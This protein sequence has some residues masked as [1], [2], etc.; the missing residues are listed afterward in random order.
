MKKVI[1]IL[2]AVFLL[3]SI[4]FAQSTSALKKVLTL[5]ITTEGGANGAGVVWHP[6]HKKYYA[7]MAGNENFQMG[8]FDAKGKLVSSDTLTTMVDLRGLWYNPK[9]N[10]IQSNAYA[11][12]GWNE[13][14]L[15]KNGIPVGI[16]NLFE[17]MYQPNENGVG[18]YNPT[19]NQVYFLND[20]DNLLI[21]IYNMKD[22]TAIE[23]KLKLHLQNVTLN[24]DKDELYLD[25]E[26][27]STTALYT[28]IIKKEILLLNIDQN[29]IEFYNLKNGFMTS[30]KKFPEDT[31]LESMFNFAYANGIFWLFNKADR[32]WIGYK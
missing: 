28:G 26:Y 10:T 29:Q 23:N 22:A 4:N 9:L 21:A 3:H 32:E 8:V 27:N 14:K 12:G 20:E 19:T 24:A 17:G 16:K 7:G 5:K 15:N 25:E 30:S 1:S 6:I 13:Y 2:I 11:S 31:K 18:T